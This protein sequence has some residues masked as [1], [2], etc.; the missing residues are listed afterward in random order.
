M[1]KYSFKN[2]LKYY[3][4]NQLSRRNREVVED[5]FDQLET[6][7]DQT[8]LSE[9]QKKEIKTKI[10]KGMRPAYSSRKIGFRVVAVAASIV[11]I[12]GISFLIKQSFDREKVIPAPVIL[13][14]QYS[15]GTHKLMLSDGTIIWLKGKS[16]LSYPSAFPG[17]TRQV[18]LKGEALFEVAKDPAHPFIIHC[19]NLSAKVLGTSFNIL[20]NEK[21]IEVSVFTGKVALE[22]NAQKMVV[23]PNEKAVYEAKKQILQKEEATKVEQASLI[24]GTEYNMM[25][26]NVPLSDVLTRIETK[27][28]VE[29]HCSDKQ[30][31]KQRVTAD[32]TDQSLDN[33]LDMLGQLFSVTFSQ[34]G[35]NIKVKK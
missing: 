15:E 31:L 12:L 25:F 7:S 29:V 32:F 8:Q 13:T 35:N 9:K 5:W 4:D 23:L 33:T 21:S 28:N 19:G 3:T 24:A 17:E 30:L 16:S 2:I 22:T 34:S 27:F 14:A 1:K 26:N 11:L 10:I 6:A 20:S 18:E